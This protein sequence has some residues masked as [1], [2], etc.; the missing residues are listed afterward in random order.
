MVPSKA[1]EG[2]GGGGGASVWSPLVNIQL[3]WTEESHGSRY[4]QL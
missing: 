1:A 4:V 2:G 3:V